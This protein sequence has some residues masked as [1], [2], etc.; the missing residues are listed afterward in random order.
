MNISQLQLIEVEPRLP[1]RGQS[2]KDKWNVKK[3]RYLKIHIAVDIKSKKILYMQCTDEHPQDIN[4][5]PEL[6]YKIARSDNASI[7]GKLFADAALVMI[8]LDIYQTMESYLETKYKRMLKLDE[9]REH[10]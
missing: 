10:T 3:Y 6:V 5:L 7:I 8:F 1:N 4:A 2:M 9:K